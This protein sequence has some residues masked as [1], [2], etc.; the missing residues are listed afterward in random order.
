MA[1]ALRAHAG[2]SAGTTCRCAASSRS[3]PR[4]RRARCRRGCTPSCSSASCTSR[5]CGRSRTPAPR[6]RRRSRRSPCGSTPEETQ[7]LLDDWEARGLPVPLRALDSPYRE[8]TR[9]IVDYVRGIRRESPRDLVDRLHPRVRR[10]A[11]VGADPAQPERPAAQDAGC[12]S[13]PASWSPACPGSWRRPRAW[14]TARTASPAAGAP[15]RARPDELPATAV[16]AVAGRRRSR[17][18]ASRRAAGRPATAAADAAG[19]VVRC[20]SGRS[21]TAGTASPGTR[22]GS[23]SSGTRCPASWS[24]VRLTRRREG[25]RFWRATPSRWSRRRPTGSRPAAPS[26]GRAG[27]AAATG[28]TPRSPAQRA[29]KARG[30]ARAAGPARRGGVAGARGSSRSRRRRTASAGAPGCASPSTPTAA[31]GC[32]ATA[33]TTSCR[34]TRARSPHPEVDA[35]GVPRHRWPAAREVE[36]VA[37]RR[38][39]ERRSWS[40]RGA[41]GVA[42]RGRADASR[43]SRRGAAR[44]RTGR[45]W[46]REEVLVDASW[47]VRARRVLAGPPGAAAGARWTPSWRRPGRRRGSGRSTCTAAWACSPPGWPRGSGRRAGRWGSRRAARGRRR[48]PQPARPARGCDCR[49]GGVDAALAGRRGRRRRRRAGPAAHRGR[50]ARSSSACSALRPR[51]V[52]YVACDPRRWPATCGRRPGGL[53]A[54]AAAGVRPVPDDPPRGVRRDLVRRPGSR[55]PRPILAISAFGATSGGG[56]QGLCP[57]RDRKY[58]DVEIMLGCRSRDT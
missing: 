42:R 46:V 38:A 37:I 27:A 34:S 22:A 2:A 53:P 58:L 28:S 12:T 30:G 19:T 48:P 17:P 33:R 18:H 35:V 4:A 39:A 7:R 15:R 47:R 21:R 3:A 52:A 14:R 20:G 31:P 8:V 10:R 26:P 45:G 51:V 41:G 43:R 9:P 50:A 54:R 25:D 16:R 24:T 11:L 29:L 55:P 13:R 57:S 49:P 56:L 40:S 6:G 1:A 36:V 32:A 23:C 5:R 44:A